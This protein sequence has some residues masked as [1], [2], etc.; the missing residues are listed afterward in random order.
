MG[1]TVAAALDFCGPRL[2]K[3]LTSR[4]YWRCCSELFSIGDLR[5]PSQQA[6]HAR[7]FLTSCYRRF[8]DR[9]ANK[10]PGVKLDLLIER[11]VTG[12]MALACFL[13]STAS[14]SA[15]TQLAADVSQV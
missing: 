11:G 13:P 15:V 12:A 8:E 1:F 14:A 10:I 2:H 6:M 9:L 4:T 7:L 3:R 5:T